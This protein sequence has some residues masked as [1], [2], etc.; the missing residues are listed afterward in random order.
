MHSTA[1]Q[2]HTENDTQQHREGEE[3]SNN[4]HSEDSKVAVVGIRAFLMGC[5]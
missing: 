3:R 5:Y 2:T 1:Q 4:K